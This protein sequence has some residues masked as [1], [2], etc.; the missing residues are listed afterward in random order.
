MREV[1]LE[2]R[3]LRGARP[4]GA[5][6]VPL[7]DVRLPPEAIR[8]ATEVLESGWLTSGPRVAEFEEAVAA[9][10]G[11]AHAVACSSGTAALLLAFGAL[12]L[13]RGDEVAMPSLSFVAQAN[14][15]H[16]VGARC[17]F[18]D[19]AGGDDLGIAADALERV[20]T[21][22]IRAVV[23][24]HYGGHPCDPAV[25]E[26]ARDHGV[27]VVEDAAHALGAATSAG[28]CGA[29]GDLGCF[30][31]YGNKNL[32]L[33]EGGMVVTDDDALAGRLRHLRTNGLG[34]AGWDRY[35]GARSEY[36]VAVPG[37][38]L[39]LDEMRS[40]MGTVLLA[41]LDESI[42]LR[43]ALVAEYER[44][45]ERIEGVSLA[46]AG[47][48]EPTGRSAH[49]LAV[50]ILDEGIDRTGVV[51][52]MSEL[53]VQTGWHYPP[54]HLMTAYRRAR[55]RVPR[56]EALAARLV[57]LPLYPHMSL[58]RLAHVAD[59]LELAVRATDP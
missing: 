6:E 22:R 25:I 8:A 46:F 21:H 41:R 11:R 2:Q 33:G 24:M 42:V 23:V 10:V 18:V 30:S 47:R 59:A 16:H 58:D 34:F 45:I 28:S 37:L 27:A 48:G 49:H 50:A 19:V 35:L 1:T 4:D 17:A 52:K 55:R 26:L 9:Y 53:G 7:S 54:I 57:T 3:A 38:N 31:F 39:K 32:P 51:G 43:A 29:L 15:A 56:T 14:A 20:L 13:R 5:W 44:R 40:A 36:D 12:G